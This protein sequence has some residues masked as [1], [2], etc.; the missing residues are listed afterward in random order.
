MSNETLTEPYSLLNDPEVRSVTRLH[1]NGCSWLH[2]ETI[3]YGSVR[4][5]SEVAPEEYKELMRTAILKTLGA[6]IEA[7]KKEIESLKHHYNRIN[8]R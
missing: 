4:I 7:K 2:V 5:P 8:K 1:E 3:G 6:Q